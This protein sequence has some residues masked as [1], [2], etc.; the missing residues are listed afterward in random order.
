VFPRAGWA[1]GEIEDFENWVADFNT[2]PPFGRLFQ[3][4]TVLQDLATP[5]DAIF[6]L[7]VDSDKDESENEADN[8]VLTGEDEDRG[9]PAATLPEPSIVVKKGK[10]RDLDPEPEDL[11]VRTADGEPLVFNDPAVSASLSF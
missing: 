8:V 4:I 11:E 9:D 2:L 3:A 6:G 7:N 5:L 1:L 10:T